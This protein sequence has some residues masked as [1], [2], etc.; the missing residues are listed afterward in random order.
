MKTISKKQLSNEFL[1]ALDEL[2]K[3][4]GESLM[5]NLHGQKFVVL[6][7]KDYRVWRETAYLLS[8]SKNSEILQEALEEPLEKCKDLKDVLKELD[9]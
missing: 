5:I 7:E 3:T 4:G 6:K 8:S 1:D 9:C 2:Y